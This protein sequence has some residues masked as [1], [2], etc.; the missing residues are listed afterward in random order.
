M[1]MKLDLSFW[2]KLSTRRKR[3]YSFIFILAIT[4]LVTILGTFVPTTAQQSKDITNSLNQTV[5]GGK[6]AG[7]LAPSI[8]I[9]NFSLCLLMF[10]PLVGSIIGLAILFNTGY[11]IGA[12]LRYQGSTTTTGAAA[13]VQPSTAILALV[14]VGVTFLCEY[15][16]YSI[17]ITESVW[18]F[19]RLMQKRWGELK[20]TGILIGVVAALLATGAIVE[21]YLLYIS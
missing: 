5:T 8:F 3:I 15:L 13:S 12:E 21:T 18:L 20:Y 1:D 16:S 10:L 7:T 17:G 11:Y 14:L 4:V 19:R 9:N 6:A 2:T